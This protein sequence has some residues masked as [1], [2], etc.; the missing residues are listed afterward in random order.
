MNGYKNYKFHIKQNMFF[1]VNLKL[2]P[3]PFL[4]NPQRETMGWFVVRRKHLNY[5]DS[6]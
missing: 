3:I 2:L 1:F 5:I 4:H 6:L